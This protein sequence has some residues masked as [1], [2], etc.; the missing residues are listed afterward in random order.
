MPRTSGRPSKTDEGLI[1]CREWVNFLCTTLW[2][3]RTSKTC[4]QPFRP[5]S[6]R[7]TWITRLMDLSQSNKL[8]ETKSDRSRPCHSRRLRPV[9]YLKFNRN[10]PWILRKYAKTQLQLVTTFKSANCSIRSITVDSKIQRTTLQ[11]KGHQKQL[12]QRCK[13]NT[14]VL[15]WTLCPITTRTPAVTPT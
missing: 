2:R 6:P 8:R 7:L 11:K 12:L 9:M 4:S 10:S 13:T 15:S 5:G 1:P 3:R 14:K